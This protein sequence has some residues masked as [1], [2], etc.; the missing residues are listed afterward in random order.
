M[1]TP[2]ASRSGLLLL[3]GLLAVTALASAQTAQENCEN[4]GKIWV[5]GQCTG[6]QAQQDLCEDAGGT[7][8]PVEPSRPQEDWCSL[9]ATNPPTDT[10]NSS[11][12]NTGSNLGSSPSARAA[13]VGSGQSSSSASVGK[14]SDIEA[15]SGNRTVMLI[16]KSSPL[17]SA[18]AQGFEYRMQPSVAADWTEWHSISDKHTNRFAVTGLGNGVSHA[19]QVRSGPGGRTYSISAIPGL[20]G[21]PEPPSTASGDASVALHGPSVA[22]NG[23][24]VA[25]YLY[26]VGDGR[27]AQPT[28]SDERGWQATVSGLTNDH[29]YEFS[30]QALNEHGAGRVSVASIAAPSAAL[31]VAPMGLE[32]EFGVR[33]WKSLVTLRWNQ[34]PDGTVG[35]TSDGNVFSTGPTVLGVT[36]FQYRARRFGSSIWV[37]NRNTSPGGWITV[38]GGPGASSVGI[39]GLFFG[40]RYEFQVRPTGGDGPGATSTTTGVVHIPS[41]QYD[42]PWGFAAEWTHANQAELTWASPPLLLVGRYEY[43]SS[44]DYGVTWTDWSR[45]VAECEGVCYTVVSLV[46][47]DVHRYL[48]QLRKVGFRGIAEAWTGTHPDAPQAPTLADATESGQGGFSL[49]WTVAEAGST[50]TAWEYRRVYLDDDHGSAWTAWTTMQPTSTGDSA[51]EFK[52]EPLGADTARGNYAIQVRG[53]NAHGAGANS[54]VV[55]I[56]H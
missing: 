1:N 30:A 22:G 46:A 10:N 16:W 43:R 42:G 45:A 48:F 7:Y 12:T 11:D 56:A 28:S 27:T 19:F 25:T 20:P 2:F 51:F 35:I 39:P 34:D 33:N 24:P 52:I 9:P 3:V 5:N 53:T 41:R 47:E 55:T 31:P 54:N 26:R 36:A 15:E 29:S 4:R 38:P 18:L 50:A 23:S 37:S 49:R 6:S 8:I 32:A 21:T 17:R 13:S 44:N 40:S 14:S